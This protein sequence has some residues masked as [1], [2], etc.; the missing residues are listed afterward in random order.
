MPWLKKTKPT[1]TGWLNVSTE[2]TNGWAGILFVRRMGNLVLFRGKLTAA[3]ATASAAWTMPPGFNAP[4]LAHAGAYDYGASLAWTEETTPKLRRLNYYNSRLSIVGHQ[5]ADV[6][7]I[8]DSYAVN[9]AWPDT[10]PGVG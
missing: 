4:P 1:D 2:L 6:V 5:A 3:A 7:L 8:S 9:A 10:Y